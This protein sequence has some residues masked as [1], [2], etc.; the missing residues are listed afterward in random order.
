MGWAD[1]LSNSMGLNVTPVYGSSYGGGYGSGDATAISAAIDRARMEADR[2]YELRKQHSKQ[3]YQASMMSART[4]ADAQ[5]ATA[6]YQQQQ[7][8]L[9][10]DRLA[11]DRE[12]QAQEFGLKQAGLG[13]Q[14]LNMSANL[15]GPAD[16]FAASN[17]ARGAAAMPGTSTFLDA[18]K[19]NTN[20][21]GF[22]AQ[23]GAPQAATLNTLLGNLQTGGAAGGGNGAAGGGT[24]GQNS[25]DQ[26]HA[27]IQNIGLQGA[28][29]LGA[30]SLEQLTPTE[31]SL[32]KGGL[33]TAGPDGK[34][35]D[36]NTFLSQY[37]NSRI[38]Q[39]LA[40]SAAA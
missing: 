21:P 4:A 19:S 1:D 11:F 14:L 39:G 30:G 24:S 29:K 40:G 25:T 9:A 2:D 8:E 20:L 33:E 34:A 27:Q 15:R 12:V 35:F 31:L 17:L 18:L 32:F 28:H 22:G 3:Q 23:A 13:Y 26:L 37:R 10:R 36:W 16:Y 6:R 7:Y 38:G 5:R